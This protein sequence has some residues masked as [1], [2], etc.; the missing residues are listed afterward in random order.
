MHKEQGMQLT[1]GSV[2][3][4]YKESL[5]RLLSNENAFHFMSS[6]KGI[7]AYWK[8]FLHEVPAMVKQL[9]IPTYFS[10]LSCAE[11]RWDELPQIIN[12]LNNLNLNDEEI[13]NLTYQQRTKP[14]NDNPVLVA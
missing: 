3:Q 2:R 12:K 11:L 8:Q 4:D 5:K 14:L 7:P 9:G 1:A 6:V 10:T 13:R